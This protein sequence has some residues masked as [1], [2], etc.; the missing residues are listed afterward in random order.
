VEITRQRPDTRRGPEQWFTGEVWMDQIA[1][2][3]APSRLRVYSVHFTPG[4]RTAWHRHPFG[5]VTEGSGLV[6]RR[7][8]GVERIGPGDTVRFEPG[9]DHWHGAA[10]ASFMT[11]L[12]MHET[13]DDGADAAWGEEVREEEYSAPPR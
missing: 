9:E 8:A 4:A 13:G 7:G 10:P 12:A 6:Q 5:H 2:A 3:P 1:A 11:H